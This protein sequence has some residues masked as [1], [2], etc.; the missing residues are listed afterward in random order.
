[1]YSNIYSECYQSATHTLGQYIGTVI[2][3]RY[4]IPRALTNPDSQEKLVEVF[5]SAIA[6]TILE[7]PLLQVG[8]VGANSKK[9]AW[10]QL[11]SV[12]LRNHVEWDFAE[13]SARFDLLCRSALQFQ[14]DTEFPNLESQP[15]WRISVLHQRESNVLEVI[16]SFNHA[17]SDGMGGKIFHETLLRRL[18][19]TSI[20]DTL[21]TLKDRI[22]KVPTVVDRFPPTQHQLTKF[23]MSTEFILRMLWRETLPPAITSKRTTHATWAP[24]RTSPYKT[25]FR[26]FNIDKQSLG[27][28]LAACR[29]HKTT[30]TGL[31]HALSLTSLASQLEESKARAFEAASALSMRRFLPSQPSSHPWFEPNNTIGNLV[32]A[33]PHRFNTKTVAKIRSCIRDGGGSDGS[34][35]EALEATIWEIA[36]V[37]RTELEVRLKMGVKNDLTGVMKFVGDWHTQ[38]QEQAQKPRVQSWVVSNLGVLDGGGSE[39]V[40]EEEKE[41]GW[42]IDQAQFFLSAEVPAAALTVS[43]IAVK[44]KDLVVSVSW[45]DCVMD[46]AFGE[47]FI[48]NLERWS[49]QLGSAS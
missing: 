30:I 22:L 31:L 36:A 46:C 28:I 18:N 9:P 5:E 13:N 39:G 21:P 24:I 29:K 27:H 38:M 10:T 19:E 26:S 32:S 6:R 23:T 49:K 3:C 41:D 17:N 8:L 20:D 48:A 14:L 2:A 40:V 37:V 1:M 16:F 42:S 4:A 15:G 11:E 47:R 34:L 7:H 12:D 25:Q 33:M 45:Q 43:P 35:S 44:G